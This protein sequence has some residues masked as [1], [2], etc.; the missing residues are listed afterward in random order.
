MNLDK[1][2]WNQ[3]YIKNETGWDLGEIS[4]PLKEYFDQLKNKEL[5]IIIPGCGNAYEAEY[6][7]NNGFKNVFLIDLSPIALEQFKNRVPIFPEEQLICDDFFN[8]NMQY[9]LMVEQTFFCAINPSL[10]SK[11]AQ[12]T[13]DILK[14]NG[15]LIGLL[16]N[17]EL[18]ADHPP[19]GGNKN[20]YLSYFEPYF[21]INIMKTAHNSI[22]PRRGR[23][24]FIKLKKK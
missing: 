6:L 2:F 19:F 15:R 17:D 12:H 22:K 23:E 18:N 8:H 9:D 11:Y 13:A 4:I 10:R 21:H 5:R 14:P 24:L 16:F 1:G 3:R 7:F 20:E